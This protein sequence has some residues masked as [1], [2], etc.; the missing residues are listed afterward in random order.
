MD[1]EKICEEAGV[2]SSLID[3]DALFEDTLSEED[4]IKILKAKINEIKKMSVED[5]IKRVNEEEEKTLEKIKSSGS[6]E[7]DKYFKDMMDFVKMV[8]SKDSDIHSLFLIGAPAVGKTYNT[9]RALA[10]SGIDFKYIAGNISPMS[11]YMLL[12][13]NKD[14]VIIFDDTIGLT[15]NKQSMSVLL[16]ALWSP[17]GDRYVSWNST[18]GKLT[19]PNRFKFNGKIIFM[20][21]EVPKG[22]DFEVLMS[23]CMCYEV[24]LKYG[25]VLN[26]MYE[27][28]KLEH[29]QLKMKERVNIVDYIGENSTEATKD[30]NLRLQKKIESIYIYDKREWKRLASHLLE[31]DEYLEK[32]REL[33]ESGKPVKEQIEEFKKLG[34]SRATYFR[35]KER[36][37]DWKSNVDA[38]EESE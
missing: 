24:D 29:K 17:E 12:Y 34:K 3:F 7:I 38:E 32:V 25:E 5:E 30:F 13:E 11:C 2:D 9:I 20:L 1:Y 6:R 33:I 10:N 19:I 18:S 36:L 14:D 35:Y 16:Q 26:L 31:R 37:L 27:I 8:S 21:N 28:A 15:R 22:V 23:R 4:N